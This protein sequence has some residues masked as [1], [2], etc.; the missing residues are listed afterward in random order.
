MFVPHAFQ[1]CM[2][3]GN[4]STIVNAV[5]SPTPSHCIS[6]C[7]NTSLTVTRWSASSSAENCEK[8]FSF[9]P[10]AGFLVS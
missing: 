4:L 5:F 8:R 7:T 10:P 1:R 6:C 2:G 3:V 9:V